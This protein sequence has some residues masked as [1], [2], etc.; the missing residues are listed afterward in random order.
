MTRARLILSMAI[1]ALPGIAPAAAQPYAYVTNQA[2]ATVSVIDTRTDKVASTL[3][4]GDEP[5][6]I[7][8][9]ADGARLYIGHRTGMLVEHDLYQDEESAR[10]KIGAA[11]SVLTGPDGRTLALVLA[12]SD[13]VALVDMP[14]LRVRK[15]IR[16]GGR[17]AGHAAFSPDGRWIYAGAS[18]SDSI[19]IIDVA[20]G[21]V[22]HAIGVGGAPG[23]IVF[24]PD[25]TRAYAT[26]P[27]TREIVVIGD[28]AARGPC[29]ACGIGPAADVKI[30]SQSGA[31]LRQRR[32]APLFEPEQ[33]LQHRGRRRRVVADHRHERPRPIRV[34]RRFR[35]R[36]RFLLRCH[37]PVRR[38]IPIDGLAAYTYGLLLVTRV[39]AQ[40]RR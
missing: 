31:Q 2:S 22:V 34:L 13:A 33:V 32:M 25:G 4:A 6:G 1:L 38:L 39:S 29:G 5:R 9:S 37:R 23:G 17:N 16:V 15:T 24:H 8:A 19:E 26:V 10:A 7:A 20:R 11:R 21:A 40:L 30:E 35:R 28:L 12:D 3:A 18:G 27:A 14:T 36:L